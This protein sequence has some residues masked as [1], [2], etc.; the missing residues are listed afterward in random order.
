MLTAP[1][2]REEA[3]FFF[4]SVLLFFFFL[5]RS[6]VNTRHIFVVDCAAILGEA[7]DRRALCVCVSVP[8]LAAQR[9]KKN[10]QRNQTEKRWTTRR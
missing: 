1:L 10:T 3:S 2:T 5:V 9:E 7:V 8:L 4:L 6:H